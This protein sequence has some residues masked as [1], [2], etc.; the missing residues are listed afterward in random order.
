MRKHLGLAMAAGLAA[1]LH[2]PWRRGREAQDRLF[3]R[4]RRSV[5]PGHAARRGGGGEGPRRRGRHPD[6]AD[7]GRQRADADPRF[8]GRARR[9]QVHHH[10][11]DRQGSDGRPAQGRR[12]AGIKVITVDTFLGDGDYVKG[13]VK[14][15]ISYIGSDNVEGGRIAA[16]GLAKAI[17]GKGTVYINSTNPNVSSV[18]GREK[19]FKEAMAQGLPE[20]QGAR[21]RLQSRRSQQGGAADGGGAGARPRSCRRVRHQRVQRS[22]RGDSGRQRQ[23]SAATS[24]LSPMT[25]RSSPSSSWTRASCRWF[26][27][28]SRSIWA[29]SR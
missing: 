14:F 4:G 21:P 3:A 13:P 24:R 16:R 17:G 20:H 22:G 1:G 8:D 25:R 15:P 29:I 27:R 12:D 9:P 5:L 11:A 26:W 28:K 23:A 7:L 18:E 19:G 10:R 6:S 2:G